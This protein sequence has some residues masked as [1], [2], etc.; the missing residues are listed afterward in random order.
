MT[1]RTEATREAYIKDSI[2]SFWKRLGFTVEV[3]GPHD[4]VRSNMINGLPPVL[5]ALICERR[6]LR[7][8]VPRLSK[9]IDEMI[10][11]RKRV[12]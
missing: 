10:V 6:K 5:Y 2:T 3:S 4:A 9:P 7:G 11:R 12:E 8:V 1:T